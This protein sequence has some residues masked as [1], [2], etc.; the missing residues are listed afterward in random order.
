MQGDSNGVD[1]LMKVVES[2]VFPEVKLGHEVVGVEHAFV[3]RPM[4]QKSKL[5]ASLAD[6]FS[7]LPF[8]PWVLRVELQHVHPVYLPEVLQDFFADLV[9][10]EHAGHPDDGVPQVV[11]VGLPEVADHLVGRV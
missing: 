5:V 11:V 6:D 8:P 7:L 1:E 4:V 9:L 3:E 2:A 10:E